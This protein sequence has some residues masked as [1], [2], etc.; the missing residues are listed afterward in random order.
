MA[1]R[2][3]WSSYHYTNKEHIVE[4]KDLYDGFIELETQTKAIL[5]KLAA[6]KADMGTVLEKNAELE[7]ENRHLREHLEELQKSATHKSNGA[8]ELSKSKLNL[9]NLYEEGFH[10]CPYMYGQRRIE[11]EP[12]AFC[13]DIIYG[14][15]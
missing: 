10:V 8:V 9:E 4:K 1:F 5:A 2:E 12:C 3:R 11:D 13:L 14:E 6:L 7:I 15:H